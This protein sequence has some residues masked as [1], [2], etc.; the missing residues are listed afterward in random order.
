MLVRGQIPGR[1]DQGIGRILGQLQKNGIDEN[2]MVIFLSDS[3]GCAE[4]LAENG[5]VQ[6]LLYPMR[7]GEQV[8]AGGYVCELRS[9][10][11]QRQQH[12]LQALQA[13][14]SRGRLRHS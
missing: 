8:R 2:T 1:M 5:S 3:G 12:P 11:G 10:M 6:T 7:N 9:S 13:L 14:G 4:F